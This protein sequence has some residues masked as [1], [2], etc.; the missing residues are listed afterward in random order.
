[1]IVYDFIYLSLPNIP[2]DVDLNISRKSIIAYPDKN[3][4]TRYVFKSVDVN[5]AENKAQRDA[6]IMKEAIGAHIN[7][8]NKYHGHQMDID[9]KVNF[10]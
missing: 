3:E 4:I 6:T 5:N 1:M 7:S 9:S 10:L 8:R 2:F